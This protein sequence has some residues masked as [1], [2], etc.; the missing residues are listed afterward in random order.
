MTTEPKPFADL[1]NSLAALKAASPGE[2]RII[3][4]CWQGSV[5]AETKTVTRLE[6]R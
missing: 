5:K 1:R 6:A 4:V 2:F 3:A